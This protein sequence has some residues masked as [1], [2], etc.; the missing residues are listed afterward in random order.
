MQ[1]HLSFWHLNPYVCLHWLSWGSDYILFNAASGQTH[2][3]NE[4]G[5][6]ILRLLDSNPLSNSDIG[7]QLVT[8]YHDLCLDSE[9]S[10]AIDQLLEELD[11]LG[12]IEPYSKCI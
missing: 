10:T 1:A 5:A 6:A 12:L 2:V 8:Q 9:L 11:N 3:L 4:L 7:R